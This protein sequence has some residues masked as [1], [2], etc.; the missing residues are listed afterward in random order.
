MQATTLKAADLERL[1]TQ[2]NEDADPEDHITMPS[3][4]DIKTKVDEQL[5]N[6]QRVIQSVTDSTVSDQATELKESIASKF[7]VVLDDDSTESVSELIN[8]LKMIDSDLLQLRGL[9]I[10]GSSSKMEL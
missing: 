1:Q 3:T 9:D 4:A 7:L 5:D 10:Y 6:I 2:A 8:D